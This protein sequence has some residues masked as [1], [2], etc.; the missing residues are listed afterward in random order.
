MRLLFPLITAASTILPLN[1]ASPVSRPPITRIA[2]FVV[3]TGNIE[4][5]RRFYSG[6]LGYDEVFRHKRAIAGAAELSVFKINDEQYIEVAPT[7][8]NESDDKLI[9][10]GFETA[11]ARK[12]RDYLASKGVAVPARLAK[13]PDGNYSFLVKDPEGHNVEF[14]EYLEGS[15]QSRF[16]GKGLSER[17]ISDHI[18]HAGLHVKSPEA[19]DRFYKDILGFRFLWQGG[20]RDDRPDWISYLTP[21]GDNW[22][23]YMVERDGPASARQLGVWHHVCVGTLDIQA[24]YGTVM[25]RGY[26]PPKPPAINTRDGR[27]LLHLFDRNGTRVE[28]MIRKPVQ[29]PC[30]SENRD[31]YI[32]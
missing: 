29:K 2:N 5:A 19:Q 11:D 3:K 8:A 30:C 10:L 9:Q 16:R 28:V 18:L 15:L 31:P 21:E 25:D 14:V 12:L 26:T 23:E 27:W 20:P 24:V 7:L 32:K 17:R 6:V 1:A 13:D 4:E 22:I